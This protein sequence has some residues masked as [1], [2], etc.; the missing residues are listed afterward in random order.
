MKAIYLTTAIALAGL[1]AT[2][3]HAIGVKY[4]CNVQACE[5]ANTPD[6]QCAIDPNERAIITDFQDAFVV[7]YG[8]A[9][10]MVFSPSLNKRSGNYD[11]GI[12]SDK[13]GD[14][15]YFMKDKYRPAYLVI[16]RT[17]RAALIFAKCEPL[18]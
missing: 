6:E 12:D 2:D 7:K 13:K 8:P 10:T 3:A 14:I 9:Q 16:N 18:E 11:L 15:F 5:N 17:T 1:I 4:S